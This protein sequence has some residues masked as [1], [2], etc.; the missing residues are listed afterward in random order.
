MLGKRFS[1][2][3]SDRN[4]IYNQIAKKCLHILA[5]KWQLNPFNACLIKASNWQRNASH[6]LPQSRKRF[7]IGYASSFAGLIGGFYRCQIHRSPSML[8]KDEFDLI[9]LPD[10]VK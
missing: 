5:L 6:R 2:I 1:K 4:L 8:S 9:L 3:K 10:D 7:L